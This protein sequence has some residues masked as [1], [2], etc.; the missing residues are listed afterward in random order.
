MRCPSHPS[1][2]EKAS[3]LAVA[4]DVRGATRIFRQILKA[5]P[6]SPFD[7]AGEARKLAE[8]GRRTREPTQANPEQPSPG[9]AP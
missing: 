6:T 2:R 4:G 7:P 1:V 5:Q 3:E 9:Q 8:E